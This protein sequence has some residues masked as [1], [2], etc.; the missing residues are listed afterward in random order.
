MLLILRGLRKVRSVG[1]GSCVVGFRVGSQI[2]DRHT[3]ICSTALSY[4]KLRKSLPFED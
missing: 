1:V 4:M 2:V 3:G